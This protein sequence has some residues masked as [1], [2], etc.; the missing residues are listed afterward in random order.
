MAK[1]ADYLHPDLV[2]LVSPLQKKQVAKAVGEINKAVL[3]IWK[4]NKK[5][6]Q[7]SF[8]SELEIQ[9]ESTDTGYRYIFRNR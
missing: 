5:S 6:D 9:R 1:L 7:S 4:D 8:E 2:L 3:W